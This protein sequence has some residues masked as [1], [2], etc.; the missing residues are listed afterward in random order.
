MQGNDAIKKETWSFLEEVGRGVVKYIV[1]NDSEFDYGLYAAFLCDAVQQIRDKDY[2]Q[3]IDFA[4]KNGIN[5]PEK[6]LL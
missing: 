3:I 2:F 5:V 1:G 6:L 4:N